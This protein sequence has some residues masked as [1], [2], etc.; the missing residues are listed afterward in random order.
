MATPRRGDCLSWYNVSATPGEGQ[1]D[2]ERVGEGHARQSR[3]SRQ[4]RKSQESRKVAA[5][6]KV[7]DKV[8]KVDKVAGI[9]KV[10][11]RKV[12][13]KSKRAESNLLFCFYSS[14][15]VESI[16]V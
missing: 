3:Q 16:T 8:G 10:E 6:S 5:K 12:A 1:R 14:E 9:G 15:S 2:P 7:A 4:S 11:S 13:K